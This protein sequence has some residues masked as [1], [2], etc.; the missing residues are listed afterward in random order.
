M[1]PT[2][3]M[4]LQFAGEPEITGTEAHY[5]EQGLTRALKDVP[6]VEPYAFDGGEGLHVYLHRC[7]AVLDVDPAMK[8][9]K[10]SVWSDIE[11]GDCDCETP[12][13]WM[14]IYVLKEGAK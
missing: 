4:I 1:K 10:G 7:G 14:R 13:P 5:I 6:E 2:E 12:S 3:Q 9:I 11:A 8:N